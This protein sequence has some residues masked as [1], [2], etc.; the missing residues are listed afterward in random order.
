[1]FFLLFF[2]SSSVYIFNFVFVFFNKKSRANRQEII[3]VGEI[4]GR[5]KRRGKKK[6][7]KE[8]KKRKRKSEKGIKSERYPTEA[9]RIGQEIKVKTEVKRKFKTMDG[10]K[11]NNKNG[12]QENEWIFEKTKNRG[13]KRRFEEMKNDQ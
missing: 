7:K 10:Q 11:K 13:P 9:I 1:L 6:R 8:K 3:K 5:K 12:S 4:A 2:S